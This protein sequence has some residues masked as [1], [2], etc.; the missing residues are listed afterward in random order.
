MAAAFL[1]DSGMTETQIERVAYLVGHHHTFTEI[2]GIDYQIL[3]EADYIANATENGWSGDNV[4]N[5][6]GKYFATAAGKRLVAEIFREQG[7]GNR[8]QD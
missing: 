1:A 5:F 7:T 2:D 8:E 3:I 6:V 4:R